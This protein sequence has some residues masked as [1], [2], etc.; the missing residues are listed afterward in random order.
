V[1][2]TTSR[3]FNP[4]ELGNRVDGHDGPVSPSQVKGNFMLKIVLVCAAL[5]SAGC[6]H[7]ETPVAPT[8]SDTITTTETTAPET[9]GGPTIIVS[10]TTGSTAPKTPTWINPPN[11]SG[12]GKG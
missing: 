11:S 8:T 4:I 5:L 9:T 2:A 10:T 3:R 7:H 1:A 6:T 12:I